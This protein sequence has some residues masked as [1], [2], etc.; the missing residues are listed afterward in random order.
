MAVPRADRRVPGAQPARLLDAAAGLAAC[1]RRCWRSAPAW[2][3]R[4]GARARVLRAG[5]AA[6]PGCAGS[7]GSTRC[8]ISR[9]ARSA[10]GSRAAA[11]I[12]PPARSGGATRSAW[13]GRCAS[14]GSGR[15]A[16]TCR[17][18]IPGRCAR[19]CCCCC[20]VALVE[21]GG[22]APQRLLQAFEL[23]RADPQAVTP[24]ELT[25]WVTPPLYTGLPPVRLE[26]QRP[27]G[28]RAGGG[29]R[30]A[31]GGRAGRQRGARPAAPSRPSRREQF[32]LG[33]DQ[34]A[35]PFVEIAE[36]SAEA[37]LVIERSGELRI[38]SEDEELGAWQIEAIPDQVAD[39]R[40]RRAA[41]RDP[42]RRAA[43]AV[44]RR[45]RLRRRQHRAGDEPP[46]PRGPGRA[47]SS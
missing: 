28:G 47:A 5:R 35:E 18:A 14:C 17:G 43:L 41:E 23:R 11:R 4:C 3:G 38:G 32:A 6:T 7:S 39:H 34:Q 36:G 1:A 45:R 22:M 26:A 2:P 33:L 46:R 29:A 37:S 12:R 16:R 8:P 21:A 40:V 10:T 15:R 20:V 13:R 9:C 42:S 25:L 19:R 24:I 27:A 30:A 31:A 44:H